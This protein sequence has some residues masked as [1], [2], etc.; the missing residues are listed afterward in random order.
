MHVYNKLCVV[1][2]STDSGKIHDS[3]KITLMRA[4]K[5]IQIQHAIYFQFGILDNA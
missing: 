2:L 1:V 3:N 4:L 5:D